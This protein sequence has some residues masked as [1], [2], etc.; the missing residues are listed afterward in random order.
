MQLGGD[1]SIENPGEQDPGMIELVQ[2]DECAEAIIQ[3]RLDNSK[4]TRDPSYNCCNQCDPS[5]KPGREYQWVEEN[6]GPSSA[7]PAAHKSTNAQRELILK[8]PT[9][10]WPIVALAAGNCPCTMLP[11]FEEI[12]NSNQHD[13]YIGCHAEIL[14]TSKQKTIP[15]MHGPTLSRTMV[16][17]LYLV[18]GVIIA[19][20]VHPPQGQYSC[21]SSS[22]VDRQREMLNTRALGKYWVESPM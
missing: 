11:H 13:A 19:G 18:T 16:P 3:R 10:W 21:I 5:M 7:V 8:W 17:A 20:A 6:P 1:F 12:G 15:A 2:S 14:L 4:H 9:T 22:L